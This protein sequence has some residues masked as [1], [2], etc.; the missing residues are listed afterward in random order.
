MLTPEDARLIDRL[1]GGFP[2]VDRPFAAV[3]AELG[4]SE[5][6]VIERLHQWPQ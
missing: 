2:L 3:G 4:W 6:C 1:H 5:E